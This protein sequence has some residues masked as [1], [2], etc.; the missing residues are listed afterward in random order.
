MNAPVGIKKPKRAARSRFNIDRKPGEIRTGTSLSI[1]GLNDG[2][3][4]IQPFDTWK[5]EP[6]A[7]QTAQSSGGELTIT[8]P[9]FSNDIALKVI[10]RLSENK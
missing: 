6:L 7:E 10:K 2:S 9:A 8:L 5:G 1:A 3:Y 4:A